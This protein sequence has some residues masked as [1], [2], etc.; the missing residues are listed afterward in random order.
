MRQRFLH[1]LV[2]LALHRRRLLLMIALAVTVIL[3]AATSRLTLDVRWTNLLPDSLPVV[4]EYRTIDHNFLQPANIII[5]ISGPDPVLLETITDEAADLLERELTCDASWSPER[6]K[7]EERYARHVYGRLP[8]AWLTEH[9]LRIEKPRDVERFV[10][11]VSD[12]RLFPYLARLNDDLEA[13]Y[14]DAENVR[15]QERRVVVSLDAIQGLV[16]A[17]HA[18]GRGSIDSSRVARIVR[19]LTIGRP[20]MLSLDRRISLVMVASAIPTDDIEAMPLIDR[21]IERVLAPL[22]EK[23]P[24]YSFE[25]T[26]EIAVGRDEMDSIGP[27]SQMIT[28]IAFILVFLL[29]IWNFRGGWMPLIALIPIV[30]GIVW[31]VGIVALVLGS[32]NIFTVMI[33]VVLLG[34]GIDVSLHLANRFQEEM[35]AGRSLDASLGLAL[36]ETGLGV[37]TGALTTS[38][39]F[40]A[41]MVADTRGIREFGLCAG[42]G[43]LVTLAAV[44]WI[45][46]ALLVEWTV[47]RNARGRPPLRSRDFSLLGRLAVRMGRGRR[48]VIPAAALATAAGIWAGTALLWEWNFMELE[49]AGLRSIELQD[50]IIDRYKVS[51]TL[52][53]LTTNTIEDSRNLR[54]TFKTKGLVSDVDDVS[55]W[56]S[57]PDFDR[58]VG[59]I[60]GLRDALSEEQPRLDFEES[61][62]LR[63]GLAD[64][65]DRLWAN[66]VEIQALSFI[67]GQ[68]RIVEKARQLVA[69]RE[70]R[71][72]G[73]LRRAADEFALGGAIDWAGVGELASR[74]AAELRAR[75][76]RMAEGNDPVTLGMLPEKIRARYTSPTAPGY[77]MRIFPKTNLFEREDLERFQNSATAVDPNV[78]GL[79]QMML[80]MNLETIREGKIA[81]W[82]ALAVIVLL[83]LAD[84]R[85]P[86]LVGIAV[87]PLLSG[88]AFTLGLMWLLGEKLHYVNVI[89][90]PVIIGIGVDDGVHFL[91]RFVR[92]G[93][94]GLGRAVTGVGRAMLMTS[95]TTMIGFGSLMLYLMRGMASLGLV[96][97]SGVGL[98]L[99]VTFTLLP[100]LVRTLESRI[101][102]DSS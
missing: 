17:I 70:N 97:F 77:L 60:R 40:F 101:L 24:D 30:I 87:L 51:M 63:V 23:Y 58:S 44:L 13:E 47:R 7:Q 88:L 93:P 73:P 42:T 75:A 2:L 66:L 18:A 38:A 81:F 27:Q 68:D 82:T 5:A 28:L 84:F 19:D 91:H 6:C 48:L 86:L 8:E 46:P 26:G 95:L 1:W 90:L 100:A 11:V 54:E 22:A 49:P 45:L 62:E 16:E 102:R 35:A 32:M 79:P 9:A 65:L 15:A 50:E 80:H 20:Y 39:A 41:L 52:S 12:P 43:V 56:V 31:S 78:T 99:V 71:A 14:A 21:K 96:L 76:M 98:C 37:I 64:E 59:H 4:R 36:G 72:D 94:G 61:P 10:D 25:R 55:L 29:L 92:E 33:G 57:R 74:F 89:A 69:G 3:G 34:L 53:L 83:L 85:R 67:A